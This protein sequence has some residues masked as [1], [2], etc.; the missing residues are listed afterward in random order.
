[1]PDF[2]CIRMI[3]FFGLVSLMVTDS[4]KHGYHTILLLCIFCK[5]RIFLFL[6]RTPLHVWGSLRKEK[7]FS[8]T[9]IKPAFL[10]NY[11]YAFITMWLE[12]PSSKTRKVF[13]HEIDSKYVLID[14]KWASSSLISTIFVH[15][16]H[17]LMLR[18]Q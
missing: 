6:I 10:H 5:Y 15:I 2:F 3:R 18:R 11:L 14:T 4:W 12:L 9:Y 17:F 1:M 13:V 8:R 16:L 7:D